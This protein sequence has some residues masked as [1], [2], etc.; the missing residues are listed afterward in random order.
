MQKHVRR[1]LR[2]G[3]FPTQARGADG[4]C[5]AAVELG[6]LLERERARPTP[7]MALRLL[8]VPPDRVTSAELSYTKGGGPLTLRGGS[9]LA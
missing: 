6:G 1:G 7:M 4:M 9:L 3:V 5:P 8:P 2:L